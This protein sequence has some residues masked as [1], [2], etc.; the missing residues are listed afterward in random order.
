MWRAGVSRRALLTSLS[1]RARG[2]VD[3][4]PVYASS[5]YLPA[6][7]KASRIT[8]AHRKELQELDKELE[9]VKMNL[10]KMQN[11]E[12]NNMLNRELQNHFKTIRDE[13]YE[14]EKKHTEMA[15]GFEPIE[16]M[17]YFYFWTFERHFF[18]LLESTNQLP[19]CA[20]YA[21]RDVEDFEDVQSRVSHTVN[22]YRYSRSLVRATWNYT[23]GEQNF[24]GS[25]FENIFIRITS[26]WISKSSGMVFLH[27]CPTF[28]IS[29]VL[30][31]S[32]ESSQICSVLNS[33][34]DASEDLPVPSWIQKSKNLFLIKVPLSSTSN[35]RFYATVKSDDIGE[36]YHRDVW[37]KNPVTSVIVDTVHPKS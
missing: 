24:F 19:E 32:V 2:G 16:E 6:K 11:L 21:L 34:T 31:L 30:Q 27:F 29:L 5:P 18:G 10:V 23:D 3:D 9:E 20:Q 28:R 12:I 14:V 7:I 36:E 13:D 8:P 37:R 33:P 15:K 1:H 26:I 17:S 35:L 22:N 25:H 4:K